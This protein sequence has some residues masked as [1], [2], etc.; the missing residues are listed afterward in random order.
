MCNVATNL[1]LLMAASL[2]LGLLASCSSSEREKAEALYAQAEERMNQGDYE[3]AIEML[4]SLDHTYPSEVE[5]RRKGMHLRPQVIEK[6]SL[7]ELS[8]TDSLL[9]VTQ[10]KSDSVAKYISRVDNPIEPYYVAADFK[11]KDVTAAPGLYARITPDGQFYMLSSVNKPLNTTSVTVAMPGGVSAQT[12]SVSYDGERND[13]QGGC[14]V[15]TFMQA[16]CDTIG[17]LIANNPDAKFTLTFN[18]RKSYT[19]PLPE[20]QQKGIATMYEAASLLRDLKI[21]Q[22]RKTHLEKQLELAR[23]QQART[24][25]EEKQGD[26]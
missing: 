15:I 20:N 3:L 1:G 6:N 4:D 14:E 8:Q 12:S 18:G 22:I 13:R 23:S 7:L 19:M 16:E 2:S 5:V 11:G 24:F 10:L 26:E 9:A 21:Y 25:N 17:A